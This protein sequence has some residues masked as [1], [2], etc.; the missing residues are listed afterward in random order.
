LIGFGLLILV[1]IILQ[2]ATE[3]MSKDGIVWLYMILVIIIA[4]VT[5]VTKFMATSKKE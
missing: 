1:G 2:K 4:V 3:S 5:D